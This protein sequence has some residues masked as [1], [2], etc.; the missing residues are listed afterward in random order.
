MILKLHSFRAT[1]DNIFEASGKNEDGQVLP[2]Q[3]NRLALSP[4]P[5]A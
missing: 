4:I 5:Y 1:Q 2:R 3:L